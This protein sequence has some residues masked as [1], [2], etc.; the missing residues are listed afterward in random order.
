MGF[1]L[2]QDYMRFG[3]RISYGWQPGADSP[4]Q[5]IRLSANSSVYLS[6]LTREIETSE[7][8]PSLEVD[9]KRGDI[10][11]LEGMIVTENIPATFS[12]SADVEIPAG[13]YRY[14]ATTIMYQTP[15][16]RSLRT[17]ITAGGGG[18][19][20]GRRLTLGVQPYWSPSRV[21]DLQLFYQLNRI[22][23]RERARS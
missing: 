5:R 17:E 21:V 1:Q 7:T 10:V 22:E 13:S 9:W 3:D 15:R 6:N 2:R 16:G 18:F 14:P 12:L 19:F 23:F 4:L 20:D 8:G 11:M